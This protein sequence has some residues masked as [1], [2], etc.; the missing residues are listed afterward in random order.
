MD[1]AQADSTCDFEL[2]ALASTGFNY[3]PT[4]R[5]NLG[6]SVAFTQWKAYEELDIRFKEPLFGKTSA[7][8]VKDW[9]NVW[10]FAVGAEYK[11]LD[12]LTARCGY[13]FDEEPTRDSRLDYLVPANDRHILSCGLG[14]Q[15]TDA[16][17]LDVAYAYLLIPERGPVQGRPAEGVLTTEVEGETHMLSATL[18]Y[19]F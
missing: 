7:K 17:S 12:W 9:Y 2:P 15:L 10:R 5:W 8:S 16:L 13:V 19:R 11:A 6:A 3:Q 4:D 14:F 1:V 18:N